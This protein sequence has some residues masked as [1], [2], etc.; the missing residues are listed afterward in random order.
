MQLANLPSAHMLVQLIRF[1]LL[2]VSFDD[3]I[4]SFR[5]ISMTSHDVLLPFSFTKT[6]LKK[7]NKEYTHMCISRKQ[8]NKSSSLTVRVQF[9]LDDLMMPSSRHACIMA[10]FL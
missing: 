6:N 3:I 1:I 10:V 7:I 5:D 9:A 8:I 2:L 4:A